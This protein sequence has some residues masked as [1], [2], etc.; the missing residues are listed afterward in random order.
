MSSTAL[1]SPRERRTT[2]FAGRRG[3]ERRPSI[4]AMAGL[5]AAP[6]LL[7]VAHLLFGANQ[8][9]AAA[10]LTAALGLALLIALATPLRR[11]LDA[12]G[13]AAVPAVLFGVV[14]ATA[15]W[16]L[17]PWGPGGA[18]PAWS[19]AGVAPGSLTIDR[20]ATQL[21]IVKLL[22]L[23]CAFGLGALQGVRRDRAQATVEAIVWIGGAYAAISLISFLSG[24]QVATG[25]RLTGGFLSANSGGT[26]FGI[27]TVLGLA[28]FLRAW[29]RTEGLGATRRM[30]ASAVSIACLSL[31]AVCLI[32]TASRM[33]LVATLFASGGLLLWTLATRKRD[34][35]AIAVG[36]G[37]LIAVAG[38]LLAGGNDLLWSR[39]A[40]TESGMDVRGQLFA[41][42]WSAF[43][44][45]PVFGWGLGSFD[46]VNLQRM[47][48][49]T[50]PQLWSMRATHNVYL[51]WL[52]EAGLVGA[53]PMFLLIGWILVGA[54][55]RSG[56][57]R[58]QTLMIGLICAS[59]VVLIH[60]LTDFALQVPSIAAFWSFL[61]GL[62]YGFGRG[63]GG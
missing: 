50:A 12:L 27:L 51:Q 2:A 11:S 48:A 20:S 26:V 22:G 47:T 45:S 57:G 43:T 59:G 6:A 14:I 56:G 29:S 52:E 46:A 39:L 17:T 63:S 10:W 25:D 24:A 49:E 44:A 15:L 38:V 3:P 32:L 28:L 23:A 41:V 9:A 7:T 42:H 18:Q 53:A 30:T 5:A 58:G 54:T 35:G 13:G 60:G 4:T 19:W 8:P 34:R 37:L 62:Q 40:A 55:L 36:G 16:S 61:L 1:A 31:T 33:A 21:E